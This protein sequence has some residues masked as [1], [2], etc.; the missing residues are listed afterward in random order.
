MNRCAALV[1]VMMVVA[2][3]PAS[4]Q[5]LRLEIQDPEP[6][7]TGRVLFHI[8]SSVAKDAFYPLSGLQG[9]PWQ[10]P[11]LG[12]VVGLSPIADLEISGGPY[13]R[14]DITGRRPASLAAVVTATGD[15]THA[16]EDVVIGTKIRLAPETSKRPAFGFGTESRGIANVGGRYAFGSV[17]LDVAV[18][19]GVTRIDPSI[20]ATIGLTCAFKAFTLP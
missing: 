1:V 17:R 13:N 3:R 19:R 11:M 5:Q 18:L 4:A 6:I 15:T 12:F 10:L 7:G 20:G 9:N 2:I 14:L 16:V 8:E